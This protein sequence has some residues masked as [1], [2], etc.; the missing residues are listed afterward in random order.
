[1][2]HKLGI[3]IELLQPRTGFN[4]RTSYKGVRI[5]STAKKIEEEMRKA[6]SD[7]LGLEGEQMRKRLVE[8]KAVYTKSWREGSS[9]T[10]MEDFGR[11]AAA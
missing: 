6:F 10:A 1:M 11:F 2:S 4:G 5:D 8:V 9:R 7:I 3:S